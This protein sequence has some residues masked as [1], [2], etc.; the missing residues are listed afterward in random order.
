MGGGSVLDS[1]RRAHH[2]LL[3]VER[4]PSVSVTGQNRI[5]PCMVSV[6][7]VAQYHNDEPLLRIH[8]SFPR[9]TRISC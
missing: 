9:L 8:Y 1:Q 7:L 4:K 6:M 2:G 5:N 3:R